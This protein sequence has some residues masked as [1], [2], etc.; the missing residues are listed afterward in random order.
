LTIGVNVLTLEINL[1][2]IL[3]TIPF[4]HSPQYEILLYESTKILAFAHVAPPTGVA[5]LP[6]NSPYKN[7]PSFHVL[8]LNIPLLNSPVYHVE[9]VKP[10]PFPNLPLLN[11]P[12]SQL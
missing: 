4:L 5:P 2:F 11:V 12:F 10:L 7:I 6:L 9:L 3:V 8:P 1:S